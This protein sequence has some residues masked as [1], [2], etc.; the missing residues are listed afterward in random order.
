MILDFF[1]LNRRMNKVD[2]K[3]GKAVDK[4]MQAVTEL[5]QANNSLEAM[6]GECEAK[7]THYSRINET[8]KEKIFNNEKMIE[9]LKN[10]NKK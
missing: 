3:V 5:S 10:I 9:Q 7:A 6:S 1:R 8:T 2:K 4:A